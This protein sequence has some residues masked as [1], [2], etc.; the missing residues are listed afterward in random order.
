MGSKFRSVLLC[1][2]VASVLHSIESS[3]EGYCF[4]WYRHD[5]LAKW[6]VKSTSVLCSINKNSIFT[7]KEG[8]E[9]EEFG[10]QGSGDT[11]S[12]VI[13]DKTYR[14]Q[15]C[16]KSTDKNMRSGK[17]SVELNEPKSAQTLIFEIEPT[18]EEEKV[19]FGAKQWSQGE[20]GFVRYKVFVFVGDIDIEG[21]NTDV[22]FGYIMSGVV[23]VLVL[24]GM[25][26]SLESAMSIG[27]TT[28]AIGL[29]FALYSLQV[30]DIVKLAIVV[31]GVTVVG[32]SVGLLASKLLKGWNWVVF[33]VSLVPLYLFI[34]L[35]MGDAFFIWSLVYTIVVSLPVVCNWMGRAAF[36][37]EDHRRKLLSRL[38][39]FL[40]CLNMCII[41]VTSR[42]TEGILD[43]RSYRTGYRPGT[44]S[45]V[46]T[47][48][49][50][51]IVSLVLSIVLAIDICVMN[52]R[53]KYEEG[54]GTIKSSFLEESQS[55]SKVEDEIKEENEKETT[56]DI[57]KYDESEG[58]DINRY[59]RKKYNLDM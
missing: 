24:F 43:F 2:I 55:I 6:K 28:T 29:T 50:G 17:I 51:S 30:H 4:T 10:L 27:M 39:L 44:T 35:T 56:N 9:I 26:F 37:F 40:T 14:F 48:V 21:E 47:F 34:L 16:Y 46:D 1:M 13:R 12:I 54:N 15:D 33:L 52:K 20:N 23:L 18:K 25:V 32:L 5:R 41:I 45:A 31:S 59:K 49:R 7:G 38:V 11:L 19:G 8:S 58:S 57:V 42:M 53:Y 3:E 22:H 36:E